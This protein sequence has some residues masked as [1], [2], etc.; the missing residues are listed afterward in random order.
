VFVDTLVHGQDIAIPLGLTHPIPP[1]AAASAA[2]R[3]WLM[4]EPLLAKRKITPSTVVFAGTRRLLGLRFTAT[5]VA[6]SVGDGPEVR[7]PI[8][9]ILLAL[10]GRTARLS[11]LSGEGTRALT[12]E[13]RGVR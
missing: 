10:T 11:S 7:G 5:D 1:A 6:W 8:D 2:S 9:G 4:R 13:L 3:V 12:A